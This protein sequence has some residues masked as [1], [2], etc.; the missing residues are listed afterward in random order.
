MLKIR[1]AGVVVV[2]LLVA[3]ACALPLA[4]QAAPA[5]EFRLVNPKGIEFIKPIAMIPHNMS[6]EGKTVV[7]RWNGKHNGDNFLTRLAELLTRSVK[8]IKIVKIWEEKPET[9]LGGRDADIAGGT[10]GI[11]DRI[12]SYK[13]DIVIASQAD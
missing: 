12:A 7:L 11:A 1:S 9:S 8:D 6:L 5:Q 2:A 3:M 13:P 10:E 4:L